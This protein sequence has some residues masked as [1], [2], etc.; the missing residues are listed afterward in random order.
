MAREVI[1]DLLGDVFFAP[2]VEIEARVSHHG[3]KTFPRVDPHHLSAAKRVLIQEGKIFQDQTSHTPPV[4]GYRREFEPGKSKEQARL[5]GTKRKL[6]REYFAWTQAGDLCGRHAETVALESMEDAATRAGLYIPPQAIGAVRSIEGHEIRPGPIDLWAYILDLSGPRPVAE[7]PLVVEVKNTNSWIYPSE[8][9]LWQFL[10]KVAGLAQQTAVV[11]VLICYRYHTM[12]ARMAKDIGILFCA[13][14]CQLFSPKVGEAGIERVKE[15]LALPITRHSGPFEP[16]V[17][18]LTN[19]LRTSPP[20]SLPTEEI[21]WYR[22]QAGRFAIAAPIV[23]DHNV[24]SETLG[25]EARERVFGSFRTRIRETVPW[26]LERG[27]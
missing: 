27:W 8:R 18:F 21:P 20:P 14:Y 10:V 23:L 15:G 19:R 22:R 13:L 25:T 24:L 2:W 9:E 17:G 16:I 7:V 3:W 26:P 4:I 1:L 12:A 11:P 6:Y 5:R